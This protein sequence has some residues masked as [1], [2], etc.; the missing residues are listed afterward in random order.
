MRFRGK[1]DGSIAREV[2]DAQLVN[3][4]LAQGLRGQLGTADIGRHGDG[5]NL[6][7][8]PIDVLAAIFGRCEATIALDR[9]AF[10]FAG[11]IGVDRPCE[12]KGES[13][14]RG[15]DLR[16]A[17]WQ[18]A[19]GRSRTI[20]P[21]LRPPPQPLSRKFPMYTSPSGATAQQT[22]PSNVSAPLG[23]SM[24]NG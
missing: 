8:L 3:E 11:P 17:G 5:L 16:D 21:V 6:D 12:L 24:E 4:P 22:G 2:L 19:A 1:E 7:G 20:E 14:R 23:G 13:A 10:F 15:E 9:V 18:L